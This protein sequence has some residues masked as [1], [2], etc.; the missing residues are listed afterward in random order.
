MSDPYW[1]LNGSP[2]SEHYTTVWINGKNYESTR[3]SGK[4]TF[5]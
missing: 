1:Q 3:V 2:T 4:A 5:R